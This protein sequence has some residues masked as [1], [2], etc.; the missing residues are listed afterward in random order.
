MTRPGELVALEVNGEQIDLAAVLRPAKVAGRLQ[1]IQDAL[2]AA[3]VRQAAAR[4]DIEPTDEELQAA[5]DE[6]RTARELYDAAATEAWLAGHFL[7]YEDWEAWLE[8]DVRTRKLREALTA[9]KVEQHFA[10]NRLSFDTATISE[11]LAGDEDVARELRLQITDDGA[12]FHAL[13]R[14]H[15]RAAATRPA[16]GYVGA[17]RRA[18]LAADAEAAVFGAKAGALV[19]PFKDE[20]GWVLFKVEAVQ[21]GALDDATREQI[22]TQLFQEW[23]AEQR[24]K[25]RVTYTL[26]APATT[27]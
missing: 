2:D 13:A 21:R 16:G 8:Q 11:L 3:L 17:V 20:R 1:F 10:V 22:K 15:S 18:D 26:L 14:Q 6:F 27:D 12:D 4:R 25:A 24:R 19:G 23:L 9:D 5:A 7:S